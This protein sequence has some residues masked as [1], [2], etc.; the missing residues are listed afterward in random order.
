M[1][2]L[3]IVKTCYKGKTQ[4]LLK[5][6]FLKQVCIIVSN[7]CFIFSAAVSPILQTILVTDAGFQKHLKIK[8]EKGTTNSRSIFFSNTLHINIPFQ[9]CKIMIHILWLIWYFKM[10]LQI[11]VNVFPCQENRC[12]ANRLFWMKTGINSLPAFF[13]GS[14]EGL[15]PLC[16]VP[17]F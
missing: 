15:Q 3:Q 9:H 13:L 1:S 4:T 17:D 6:I 10:F 14:K 8:R 11:S 7:F 16:S 2:Y 5:P 12:S